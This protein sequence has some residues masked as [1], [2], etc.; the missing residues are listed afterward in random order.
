MHQY[1]VPVIKV[2]LSLAKCPVVPVW[3]HL[4]ILRKGHAQLILEL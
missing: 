1:P 3:E 4:E 2:K